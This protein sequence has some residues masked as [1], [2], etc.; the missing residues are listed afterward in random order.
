VTGSQN[1]LQNC[2]T[3]VLANVN[4]GFIFPANVQSQISFITIEL[5][6]CFGWYQFITTI[7]SVLY[8][9]SLSRV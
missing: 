5:E 3:S 8:Y 4:P 2:M 9:T 6:Y 7:S 1:I